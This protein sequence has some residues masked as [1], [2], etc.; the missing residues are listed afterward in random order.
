MSDQENE[1]DMASAQQVQLL[2]QEMEL[3]RLKLNEQEIRMQSRNDKPIML[4]TGR[5]IPQFRDRPSKPGDPTL[6][7]W[8]GDLKSQSKSRK[9]IDKDFAMLICDSLGG[10]ARQEILAR[11]SDVRESPEKI[12]W[13]LNKVFGDGYDLP[14]AQQRFFGYK[15]QPNKDL[16]TCSLDLIEIYDKIIEIDP[17]FTSM[18]EQALKSQ[19]AEAVLDEFHKREIRRLSTE[20]PCLSFLD[21]RDRIVD[22]IGSPIKVKQVNVQ[23][24]QSSSAPP[25]NDL[26]AILKRQEAIIEKQQRQT[27][28][29]LSGNERRRPNFVCWNCGKEG[30]SQRQ[31]KSRSSTHLNH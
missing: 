7:D 20:F 6:S 19:L 25:A 12:F 23:S 24:L 15:Q 27:N 28:E 29:L 26:Q 14:S 21:V 5:H 3:L 31:C 10:R 1:E 8:I 22:W 9:L 4:T 13:I 30:H 17:S 11:E 18:R 2:S 16:I